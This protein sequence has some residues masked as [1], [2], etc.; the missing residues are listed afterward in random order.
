M[1]LIV[2]GSYGAQVYK[3]FVRQ[4]IYLQS[5]VTLVFVIECY[6]GREFLPVAPESDLTTWTLRPA[7]QASEAV[8]ISGFVRRGTSI[9]ALIGRL[10]SK[11]QISRVDAALNARDESLTAE[12]TAARLAQRRQRSGE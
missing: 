3:L 12:L 9:L 7:A 1:N 2:F 6:S 11:E 5:K 4:H 8:H 10:D